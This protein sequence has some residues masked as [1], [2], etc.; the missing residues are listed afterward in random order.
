L[1]KHGR[2]HSARFAS[3][4]L[5]LAHHASILPRIPRRLLRSPDEPHDLPPPA[6]LA[7]FADL[8]PDAAAAVKESALID[9]YRRGKL[10]QADFAGALGIARTQLDAAVKRHD[11]TQDLASASEVATQV[12]NGRSHLPGGHI[13]LDALD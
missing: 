5:A 10:S 11:L 12:R 9:L 7:L 13:D 6:L 4:A 1:R 2:R 8:G 3:A